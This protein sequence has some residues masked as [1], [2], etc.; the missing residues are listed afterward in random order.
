MASAR[1]AHLRRRVDALMAEI[2]EVTAG[3]E[4]PARTGGG[5]DAGFDV[6]TAIQER[7]HEEADCAPRCRICLE[8]GRVDDAVLWASEEDEARMLKEC[9]AGD[10][11]P[12]APPRDREPLKILTCNCAGGL[13]YVHPSCAMRWFRNRA[14]GRAEGAVTSKHWCVTWFVRCE[15]CGECVDEALALS[16]VRVHGRALRQ[17]QADATTA[18]S[19]AA[20][21]D[22]EDHV[23]EPPQQTRG[24]RRIR[25]TPRG[26]SAPSA[27]EESARVPTVTPA[28]N[29]DDVL[30]GSAGEQ[31]LQRPRG[32]SA[33][34]SFLASV[35]EGSVSRAAIRSIAR[36]FHRGGS[37]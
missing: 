5:K 36:L 19:T 35:T 16:I 34:D 18:A 1:V 33:V 13:E 24:L 3:M 31:P 30:G 6:G 8:E 21:D 37:S 12:H 28:P 14:F 25:T 22:E 27:A 15:I 2:E 23:E 10:N 9:A 32:R 29:L 4:A 11:V 17:R 7:R 20:P 26:D